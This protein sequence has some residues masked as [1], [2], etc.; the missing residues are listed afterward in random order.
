MQMAFSGHK[1]IGRTKVKT[2][3]TV[4]DLSSLQI[5]YSRLWGF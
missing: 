2:D 5:D 3:N 1:Y 4:A